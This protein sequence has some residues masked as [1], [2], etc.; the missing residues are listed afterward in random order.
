MTDT[1]AFSLWLQEREAS[2]RARGYLTEDIGLL[3]KTLGHSGIVVDQ[4]RNRMRFKDGPN[5]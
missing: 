3:A 5:V 1:E 4:W 2:L